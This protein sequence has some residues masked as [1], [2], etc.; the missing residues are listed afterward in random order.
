LSWTKEDLLLLDC[1]C[2]SAEPAFSESLLKHS[3]SRIHWSK[4]LNKARD[5]GI[6]ALIYRNLSEKNIGDLQIPAEVLAEL[7][8]DYYLK[9]AENTLHFS[10]L[11]AILTAC[12]SARIAVMVLKGAALVSQ[13]YANLAVRTMA[14]I[15]LLIQKKDMKQTDTLFQK[16]DYAPIDRSAEEVEPTS[17][18][19]TSLDYRKGRK[20]S[21]SFHLHWHFVNSSVPNES[22]TRNI[23]MDNI[24]RDAPHVEIAGAPAQVLAPHHWII[25]LCEHALRVRHSLNRLNFMTD[26]QEVILY[27][28]K[29]LDWEKLIEESCAFNLNVFVY[30]G[31]FFTA[32]YLKTD[33][34]EDVLSRLKSNKDGFGTKYFM[35]AVS[36]NIRPSGMSY[37]VHLS[38]NKG[39]KNKIQFVWQTFFPPQTVIRQRTNRPES[40][41]VFIRYCLRAREILSRCLLFMSIMVRILIG[42]KR[43]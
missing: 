40:K 7:K 41:N 25:H 26:I 27:Y 16:M 29:S 35:N 17:S 6:S 23:D 13:V 34:G 4:F 30:I 20:D 8:N 5:E 31:L 38:L 39:I 36:K 2:I 21:L 43:L 10:E 32:K 9:A 1:C 19:L 42:R 22:L 15:D 28:G 14:D 24:W 18:Y 11:K 33:I 3:Q 37:L 12:N